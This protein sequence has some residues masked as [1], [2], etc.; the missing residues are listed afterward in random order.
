[1]GKLYD[2]T[3]YY[4]AAYLSYIGFPVNKVE[5]QGPYRKI[6]FFS[7]DHNGMNAFKEAQKYYN[8]EGKLVNPLRYRNELSKIR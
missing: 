1:M 3:D 4:L 5:R 6:W 2:T 8:F 7:L